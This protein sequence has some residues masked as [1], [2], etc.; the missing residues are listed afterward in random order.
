VRTLVWTSG[1]HLMW[2]D[3]GADHLM[4]GRAEHHH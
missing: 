3:G 4:C 2:M 1:V